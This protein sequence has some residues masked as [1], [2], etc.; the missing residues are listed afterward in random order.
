MN[1]D[2][3]VAFWKFFLS[4]F[5]SVS[6]L[7][8]V[9]GYFYFTQMQQQL[10]KFE[11]FSMMKYVKHIRSGS[12]S[13][14]FDDF[15]YED[16]DMDFE[17]FNVD[18]FVRNGDTFEKIFPSRG[19]RGMGRG[20]GRWSNNSGFILISKDADSYDEKVKNL[21]YKILLIQAVLLVL[22]GCLSRFLAKNALAPL[23]KNIEKLDRFAKDLIHDLNTPVT[24]IGL[25]LKLL[26]KDP[27]L[28][29][30]RA[31]KRLQQS[32]ND[33][34]DLHTNLS[35][36]L[37]EKEYELKKIDIKKLVETLVQNYCLLYPD[38]TFVT[39]ELNGKVFSNTLALNQILD[40]LISNACKYSNKQG[41][42]TFRY[43]NKKLEIIDDGIGI[44][45]TERIFERNYTEH[46]R[47]SG[48]GLDIVKRLCDMMQ[49]KIE[50]KSLEKGTLVSLEFS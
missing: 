5:I 49:V 19:G 48:I 18:N 22:F 6:L 14:G 25:N 26:H 16:I 7:I 10:L 37:T 28:K 9:A 35:F 27:A 23:R 8:L 42:I 15:S 47:G 32:A 50:I 46:N 2:E 40:N 43:K 17:D 1:R 34:S 29:E 33:I 36:L 38:L 13:D 3:T 45:N 39:N 31:L 4:Y 12:D 44:K 20:R 21:F 11:H 41:T 30:H 24:S